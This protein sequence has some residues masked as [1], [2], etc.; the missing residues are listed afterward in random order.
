MSCFF[1]GYAFTQVVAGGVA[2]LIGGEKILPYT[3]IL[4]SILT[5]L[6]PPLFNF[7]YWSG[8]P[9]FILLMVRIFTGVGQG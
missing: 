4:W 5:V 3:T 1:W 7:A 2:D 8:Y 6:T 9:L